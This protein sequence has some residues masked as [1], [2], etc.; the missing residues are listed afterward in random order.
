MGILDAPGLSLSAAQALSQYAGWSVISN[1][2]YFS[3]SQ[4][5]SAYS[6][7][8]RTEVY[9]PFA[10]TAV[11]AVYAN[12]YRS[13]FNG[14]Q[15]ETPNTNP[16][17]VRASIQKQGA[18]LNESGSDQTTRF[19]FGG[20][21]DVVIPGGRLAISDRLSFPLSARGFIKTHVASVGMANPAAPTLTATAGTGL[22]AGT[23]TGAYTIVYPGGVESPCSASGSAAA[24]ASNL[25]VTMTSPSAASFPGAIG[26][27]AWFAVVGGST[28]LY[29]S[30]SGVVPFGTNYVYSK[31]PNTNNATGMDLAVAA[32]LP[33]L[34]AGGSSNGGTGVTSSNNGEYA[35]NNGD[36]TAGGRIQNGNQTSVYAPVAVLG[37]D[38]R[39]VHRSLGIVG[40]SIANNTAD[41]AFGAA[42]GGF[43]KRVVL[44]QI[45]NRVYDTGIQPLMG[46][47]N[48]A[49]GGET[50]A[51]FAGPGGMLRTSI[52]SLCTT[53]VSDYGTNDLGA[54]TNSA[55]IASYIATIGQRFTGMGRNF[56]Q[57]TILPKTSSSDGWQTLANQSISGS[58]AEGYRRQLNAWIIST[59][60]A[61]V[62]GETPFAAKSGTQTPSTNFYAGGD[63]ATT[64]FIARKPFQQGTEVIKVNG[65]TKVLTTDYTYLG[66]ATINGVNYA[67]GVTM[68]SAPANGATVT[69]DY[70]PMPSFT[71]MC[72]SGSTAWNL[73]AV[74]EVDGSG[75]PGLNG[76]WWTPAPEAALVTGTSSGSNTTSNFNDTSKSWTTNQYRGYVVRIL[77]DTTTPAAAG[78]QLVIDG[79]SAT[80]LNFAGSAWGTAPSSA[81]TYQI[82]DPRTIDGTHPTT[83]G[84]MDLAAAVPVSEIS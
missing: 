70:T 15:G 14:V 16:I 24:S 60:A 51:T 28:P 59:S 47:I 6:M 37:L 22:T 10:V 4:S 69:A 48:V 18:T 42:I 21:S 54:G 2:S 76:G 53:I 32:A 64:A 36:F 45:S 39:K 5:T 20:R 52:V 11:A 77:T 80:Q 34:P 17:M 62:V 61:A 73:G 55:T 1:H 50:A 19:T 13:G 25:Q 75:T 38:P 84:H 29:E 57:T 35:V 83:R 46:H 82:F 71:S 31:E 79:N 8:S 67:S 43:L 49:I 78:Q 40:D 63:G 44:N 74:L 26:Y 58:T 56:R 27:R 12:S 41:T 68:V 30:G 72:G 7:T 81:A 9:P 65:A 23:Y 66:T 33:S 3:A